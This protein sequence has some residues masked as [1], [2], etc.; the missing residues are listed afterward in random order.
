MPRL[1]WG[2]FGLILVVAY[3]A[4]YTL[5]RKKWA[6]SRRQKIV[7]MIG[8]LLSGG[9]MISMDLQNIGTV[10]LPGV[11][12]IIYLMYLDLQSIPKVEPGTGGNAC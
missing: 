1:E 12:I 11:W 6:L 4:H 3:W 10:Y 7:G 9:I 8:V 5:S 2:I